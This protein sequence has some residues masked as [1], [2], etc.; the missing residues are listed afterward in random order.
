[1]IHARPP[2]ISATDWNYILRYFSLLNSVRCQLL[3]VDTNSVSFDHIEKHEDGTLLS[4]CTVCT[5]MYVR[6]TAEAA[7]MEQRV[8][9][10]EFL[11]GHKCK[12]TSPGGAAFLRHFVAA[13][14]PPKFNIFKTDNVV[15]WPDYDQSVCLDSSAAA[16]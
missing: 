4:I 8:R 3:F 13:L 16:V 2:L 14:W 5:Y 11:N 6:A 7:A 10:A 1:M 9:K 12:S 15:S